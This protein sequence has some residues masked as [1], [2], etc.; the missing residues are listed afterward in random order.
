M[1]IQPSKDIRKMADLMD[2]LPGEYRDLYQRNRGLRPATEQEG[3]LTDAQ[4]EKMI[5]QLDAMADMA[6]RRF[7][8]TD[9]K[10]ALLSAADQLM[11]AQMYIAEETDPEWDLG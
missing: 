7:R 11:L 4:L 3:Y 2:K 5:Q 1:T 9:V 8:S 10:K 6:D